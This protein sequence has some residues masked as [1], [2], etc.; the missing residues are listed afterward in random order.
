MRDGRVGMK[1]FGAHRADKSQQNVA[2][3][4]AEATNLSNLS[5]DQS[6]A[7]DELDRVTLARLASISIA[8]LQSSERR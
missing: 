1:P 3:T 7:D 8:T 4:L 6:F 2:E 5:R